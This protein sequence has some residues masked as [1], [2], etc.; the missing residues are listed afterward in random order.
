M[1][2]PSQV[3]G[4]RRNSSLVFF[5]AFTLPSASDCWFWPPLSLKINSH[6]ESHLWNRFLR[7]HVWSS[8]SIKEVAYFSYE[9]LRKGNQ[10][11]LDL[12]LYLFKSLFMQ[13][14]NVCWEAEWWEFHRDK[15]LLIVACLLLSSSLVWLRTFLSR[16]TL[17][18]FLLSPPGGKSVLLSLPH[19]HN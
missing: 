6:Q 17:N 1:V 13:L 16:I 19:S 3:L 14:S 8:D 5:G 7:R 11:L 18:G 10:V 15:T 4:S 9:R 12:S 2:S